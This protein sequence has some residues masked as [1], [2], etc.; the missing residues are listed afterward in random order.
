MRML[1]NW[2]TSF[3]QKIKTWA[4]PELPGSVEESILH[5]IICVPA[6]AFIAIV[7]ASTWAQ[8]VSE[9]RKTTLAKLLEN[10]RTRK[11]SIAST[12][13][14]AG[15]PVPTMPLNKA[16]KNNSTKCDW[17]PKSTSS[18]TRL[19][20]A[21][22]GI[23]PGTSDAPSKPRWLFFGDSTMF[24]LFRGTMDLWLKPVAAK[25]GCQIKRST[26]CDLNA[27]YGMTKSMVWTPGQKRACLKQG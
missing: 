19:L 2:K 17:G 15:N 27:F 5:Q 7:P 22:L 10:M 6:Q 21:R 23:E 9:W 4:H 20:R 24:R 8:T 26:R 16:D 3:S 18:C 14:L 1:P 11:K 13:K 25:C 12:G